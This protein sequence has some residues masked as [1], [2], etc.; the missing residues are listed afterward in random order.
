MAS[1]GDLHYIITQVKGYYSEKVDR[2][3]LGDAASKTVANNIT[4][5]AAGFF[6]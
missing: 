1:N 4:T 6:R 2:S 3:E 5:T